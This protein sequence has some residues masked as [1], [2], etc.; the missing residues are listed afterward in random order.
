M[1]N[2]LVTLY[3]QLFVFFPLFFVRFSRLLVCR[4]GD[5]STGRHRYVSILWVKSSPLLGRSCE[6][7]SAVLVDQN[8]LLVCA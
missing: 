8:T 5:S 2:D 4:A 6:V 3:P 7:M 1:D